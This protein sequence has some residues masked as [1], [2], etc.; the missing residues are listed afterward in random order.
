M[1][2]FRE[3]AVFLDIETTGM[4]MNEDITVIGLFDGTTTRSMIKGINMDYSAL[5]KELEKYKLIVTFNG[6]TFDIPFIR[7]R[8][9]GVIPPVPHIDLRTVTGRLGY[10]GGLKAIEKSFGLKRRGLVEGMHGGDVVTLWRMYRGSGDEHYLNLLVEYNEEDVINLRKIAD[11]CTK[12]ME[13][14]L[15]RDK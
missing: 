4:G 1:D 13:N 6:A 10:S 11:C 15:L 2:F 14:R 12:E 7:K 5:K 3:E 9:P 8:Y